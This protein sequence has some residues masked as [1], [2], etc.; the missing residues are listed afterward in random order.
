MN[1]FV[2]YEC[3][4]CD[5][6]DKFAVSKTGSANR[7]SFF[8]FFLLRELT[9]L[10]VATPATKP[11]AKS[12]SSSS[13]SSYTALVGVFDP[14]PVDG[15]ANGRGSGGGKEE[16]GKVGST[17]FGAAFSTGVV[18]K[19]GGNVALLGD[20]SLGDD[21]EPPEPE[22]PTEGER[23]ARRSAFFGPADTFAPTGD[24]SGDVGP[25]IV[26]GDFKLPLGDVSGGSL[27]GDG[28]VA[29]LGGKAGSLGNFGF[30]GAF[31]AP[32]GAELGAFDPFGTC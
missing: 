3:N 27:N 6:F 22:D 31:V 10:T 14:S 16:I 13:S 21:S 15:D 20:G 23:S 2:R 9:F 30:E 18:G 11:T 19:G 17:I 7:A 28:L 32:P 24:G 8:F 1:V 4:E 29:P 12:S 5:H 26:E 25:G